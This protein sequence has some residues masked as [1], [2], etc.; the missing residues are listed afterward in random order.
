MNPFAIFPGDDPEVVVDALVSSGYSEEFCLSPSF[1]PLFVASLIRAGFLVMSARMPDGRALLL[2]KIHVERSVLDFSDLHESRSALR[3]LGRY[4]LR[5]DED[6]EAV[7]SGCVQTHGDDWL[8]EELAAALG[9]IRSGAADGAARVVS[10]A[11]YRDGALVAGEFGT[12][13]GGVYTSYSGYRAEDSA[14]TAQLILT[15]RW[16]RDAGF[17]FWDLGMPLPYKDRLGARTV[18]TAA[19]VELFRR[20]RGS[21]FPRL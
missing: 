2:P 18:D 3:L 1:D 19:F 11:L 6:Y 20:G 14:G 13:V 12:I 15:G 10:F 21:P 5:F 17:S 9:A 7:F 16:L 4:E 8:T